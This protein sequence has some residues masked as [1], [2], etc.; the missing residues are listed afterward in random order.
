VGRSPGACAPQGGDDPVDVDDLAVGDVDHLSVTVAH[1]AQ[2][3]L[4]RLDRP[5]AED[6]QGD[7]GLGD[8]ER[9]D[10][11]PVDGVVRLVVLE[12]LLGFGDGGEDCLP[13]LPA[14]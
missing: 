10:E 8:V 5:G 2:E 6:E 7:L 9:G 11:G 14:P 4:P 1:A 12:R 13:E 3:A